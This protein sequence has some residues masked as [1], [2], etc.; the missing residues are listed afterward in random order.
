MPWHRGTRAVHVE[1]TVSR[2]YV[3]PCRV[4][5]LPG[6]SAAAPAMQSKIIPR[7]SPAISTAGPQ[8]SPG[9]IKRQ[10]TAATDSSVLAEADLGSIVDVTAGLILV[11]SRPREPIEKPWMRMP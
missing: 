11:S 9:R 4:A 1:L 8:S 10:L 5:L 6:L 2:A 3:T 7:I